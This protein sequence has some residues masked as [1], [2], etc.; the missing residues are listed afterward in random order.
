[1]PKKVD[2]DIVP[3]VVEPR[4]IWSKYAVELAMSPLRNQ[5]GVV[6]ELTL[7]AKFVVGVQ[8]NA[9]LPFVAQALPVLVIFPVVSTWRQLLPE[10]AAIEEKIGYPLESMVK[11]DVELVAVPAVVVVAK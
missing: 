2:V 7:T 3:I 8:A 5:M 9:P 11:A 1:L 10:D 6:V 4:V